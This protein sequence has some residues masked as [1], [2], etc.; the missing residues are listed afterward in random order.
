MI[1]G[2]C[3][4][5]QEMPINPIQT[6]RAPAAIGPYS[7]GIAAGGLLFVSGQLGLDPA[8][9][10]LVSPDFEP[11]ARQALENLKAILETAGSSLSQVVAVDV[12]IT[13]MGNFS[14]FN[15]IYQVYF[16]RHR[17]ARAVVEVSGLPKGG[18]IEIKCTAVGPSAA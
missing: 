18:V 15:D 8:T 14:A 12:F 11:Q 3:G 17:P 4:K 9:G 5:E 10:E 2:G 13:H 1:Q 7:Q 6:D 16:D